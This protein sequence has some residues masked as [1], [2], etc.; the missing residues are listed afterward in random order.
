MRGKANESNCPHKDIRIQNRMKTRFKCHDCE[1]WF[2]TRTLPDGYMDAFKNFRAAPK[3]Q[4]KILIFDLETLPLLAYIWGVWNQNIQPAMMNRDVKS[5]AIVTWS[6]KWLN[7][8]KMMSDSMTTKE[9]LIQDDERIVRS[10][11][12]LIDE[13]DVLIAHNGVR[14]DVPVF[15]TRCLLYGL[16]PPS[17]YKIIDTLLVARKQFDLPHN[18]MDYIADVLGIE[19][20]IL[21]TFDLWRGCMMGNQKDLDYMQKY[22]DKDVFILEEI[23]IKLRPWIKNHPN[24]NLFNDKVGCCPTCGAENTLK[25]NGKYQTTVNKYQSFR[26]SVCGSFS[27]TG[28]SNNKTD[29][30]SVAK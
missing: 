8:S 14:F 5:K 30:R 24:F 17:P 27:R 22:N 25:K 21:T 16:T 20:K 15:N 7:D 4:P 9:A 23:Y 2:S 10:L 18:K 28:K 13:A 29:L 6:A 1:K 19:H 26:C 12:E 3:N 11:W